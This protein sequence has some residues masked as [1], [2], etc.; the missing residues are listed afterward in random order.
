MTKL[1]GRTVPLDLIDIVT[2]GGVRAAAVQA[3]KMFPG[4]AGLISYVGIVARDDAA[5]IETLGDVATIVLSDDS[6]DLSFFTC[7]FGSNI[8]HPVPEVFIFCPT[9]YLATKSPGPSQFRRQKCLGKSSSLFTPTMNS[10][11]VSRFQTRL[12]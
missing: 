4:R 10:N 7:G 6:W 1:S 12:M 9:A 11:Q 3:C 2:V 5:P 8:H